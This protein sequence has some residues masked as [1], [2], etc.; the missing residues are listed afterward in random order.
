MWC[1]N[2][3]TNTVILFSIIGILYFHSYLCYIPMYMFLAWDLQN[4]F[5]QN[6]WHHYLKLL[7]F[8][9][10]YKIGFSYAWLF[11]TFKIN[12]KILGLHLAAWRYSM[13][14][15]TSICEHSSESH[16]NTRNIPL[17][18]LLSN[19][20]LLCARH[21][22]RPEVPNVVTM[23]IPIFWDVTP[24]GLVDIYRWYG[25]ICCLHPQERWVWKKGMD[26]QRGTT[27]PGTTFLCSVT[28]LPWIWR[29]RVYPKHW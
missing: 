12:F 27:G 28:L 18:P 1:W 26:I 29:Q 14:F 16:Q 19:K 9:V 3:C 10:Y 6:T 22:L 5:L 15:S 4:F 24:C 8:C 17:S 7:S 20:Y 2:S 23:K 13:H 25:A 11:Y 21:V